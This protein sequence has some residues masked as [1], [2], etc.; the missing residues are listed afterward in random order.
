VTTYF[1]TYLFTIDDL[2]RATM[3]RARF[4]ELAQLWAIDHLLL[5]HYVSGSTYAAAPI[6][7][8]ELVGVLPVAKSHLFAEDYMRLT[9]V[10]FAVRAP[11]KH[12]FLS[13]SLSLHPPNFCW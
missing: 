8:S 9:P 4:Q 3:L 12:T 10:T 11:S 2:G 6:S 1:L 7:D 5:L 13:L